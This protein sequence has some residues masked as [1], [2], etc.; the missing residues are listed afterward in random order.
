IVKVMREPIAFDATIV[1]VTHLVET[2]FYVNV[3]SGTSFLDSIRL[4]SLY[5]VFDQPL[6]FDPSLVFYEKCRMTGN[7]VSTSVRCAK[8]WKKKPNI[9]VPS[10]LIPVLDS[11]GNMLGE[12]LGGPFAD[13]RTR[14]KIH[15]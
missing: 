13:Q 3:V 8:E 1:V 15:G 2:W 4:K 9:S 7:D 12:L 5:G 10:S 14:M 6:V 11:V